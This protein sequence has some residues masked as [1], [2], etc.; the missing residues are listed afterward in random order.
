MPRESAHDA[1]TLAMFHL[2]MNLAGHSS[3]SGTPSKIDDGWAMLIEERL[4][5]F[6]YQVA[7]LSDFE[8]R[9]SEARQE[10]E[11]GV[12]PRKGRFVL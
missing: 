11:D 8:Q 3:Y 9:F 2:R 10:I 7:P 1:L 6:G 12:R 4:A 5:M